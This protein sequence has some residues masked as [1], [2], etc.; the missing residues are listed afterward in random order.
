M[1]GA[2]EIP[3]GTRVF[4]KTG[5]TARLCADMGILSVE[6]PDGKR[7]AYTLIGIIEKQSKARNF[8]AWIHSRGDVIRD[9]SDIVYRG[10][11]RRHDF[12]DLL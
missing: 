3:N 5:S 10:I 8:T 7:Y 2:E 9:V 12:G 1:T 4:N 11:A 6:G